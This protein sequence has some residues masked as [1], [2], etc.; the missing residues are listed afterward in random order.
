MS[1]GG[2][3]VCTIKQ[4]RQR[5]EGNQQERESRLHGTRDHND[6][7]GVCAHPHSQS[8]SVSAFRPSFL[9]FS[10]TT[11]KLFYSEPQERTKQIFLRGGGQTEVK[12]FALRFAL[13]F[14]GPHRLVLRFR[15]ID[16]WN[17]H[18]HMFVKAWIFYLH[19]LRTITDRCHPPRPINVDRYTRSNGLNIV[20]TLWGKHVPPGKVAKKMKEPTA[21]AHW[22]PFVPMSRRS[23][24]WGLEI[25]P[26]AP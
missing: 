3:G 14:Y 9:L 8:R 16:N 12:V 20:G 25:F 1:V 4:R 15:R 21:Y 13:I 5:G 26:R 10:A 18:Q 7:R 17:G 23:Y 6:D 22:T 11:A 2:G 19:S 24:L